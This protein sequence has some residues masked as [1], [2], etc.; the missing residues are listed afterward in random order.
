MNLLTALSAVKH[1]EI[2]AVADIDATSRNKAASEFELREVYGDYNALL[3][4]TNVDAVLIALPFNLLAKTI[5]DSANAGKHIFAEKPMATNMSEA[6]QIQH[7]VNANGV[8]MMVGYVYRFSPSMLKIREHV[9]QGMIGNINLIV[10]ARHSELYTTAGDSMGRRKWLVSPVGGVLRWLGSHIID[11]F[12][13]MVGSDVESVN[14]HVRIN[15]DSGMD[16]ASSFTILFKNGVVANA[17]VSMQ[18]WAEDFRF[19]YFEIFGAEGY[20]K[21]FGQIRGATVGSRGGAKETRT[22]Y[23]PKTNKFKNPVEESLP[24]MAHTDILRAELEGFIASLAR[25]SRPPVTIED[26]MKVVHVIDAIQ[27]SSKTGKTVGF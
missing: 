21:L 9:K 25:H 19:D 3:K 27:Q 5:I 18:R 17:N 11:S 12:L 2:V 24:T 22:V 14:G 7:A 20:I 26:G 13:W 1:A 6:K 16:E 10:A 4:D 15:S 8:K 23:A